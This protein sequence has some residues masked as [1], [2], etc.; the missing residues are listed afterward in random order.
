MMKNKRLQKINILRIIRIRRRSR[1]REYHR[2]CLKSQQQQQKTLPFT[3]I[4]LL[5]AFL[6]ENNESKIKRMLAL[7]SD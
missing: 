1:R 6:G 4:L 5:R 7:R 2:S 3:L